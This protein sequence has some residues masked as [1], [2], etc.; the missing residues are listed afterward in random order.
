VIGK[1]IRV[2]RC[3]LIGVELGLQPLFQSTQ[4]AASVCPVRSR[5]QQRVAQFDKAIRID[6]GIAPFVETLSISDCE[7]DL[8]AL[9]HWLVIRMR[10]DTSQYTGHA[11][12]QAAALRRSRA[13]QLEV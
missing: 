11:A 4:T 6:E 3:K 9:Q 1:P 7:N 10:P 12:W 5:V 13:V 2:R 8:I